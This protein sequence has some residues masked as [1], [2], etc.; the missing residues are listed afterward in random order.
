MTHVRGLALRPFLLS[1]LICM[2]VVST[3]QAGLDE[4]LHSGHAVVLPAESSEGRLLLES[5]G[6]AFRPDSGRLCLIT[7]LGDTVCFDDS[8]GDSYSET[9]GIHTLVWHLQEPEY[10]VVE[11]Q[12]WEWASWLLV[13]AFDGSTHRAVSIPAVSPDGSR[14][15]CAYRDIV[16][17][18]DDNG[19]EIWRVGGEGLV[20][21]FLVLD[22]E[23]GPANVL[24]VT[25]SLI[26]FD[27]VT[28]DWINWLPVVTSGVIRLNRDGT[29]TMDL[30]PPVFDPGPG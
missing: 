15:L 28:L 23:W 10:W 13:S 25:D 5:G 24:W 1:F 6:R 11:R 26:S 14:L 30:E 9:L 12:G 7:A 27:A 22:E 3:T 8:V 4:L 21:E 29:W 17:A 18:F 19:I 2:C 16:A 20:Q